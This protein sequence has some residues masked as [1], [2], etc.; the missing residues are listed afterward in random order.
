[1][2]GCKCIICHLTEMIEDEISKEIYD[3]MLEHMEHCENCS[4]LYNTF[5]KT[6]DLFHNIEKIK[7]PSKKKKVFHKWV[8]LEAKKIVIKK[9]RY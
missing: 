9:Y 4:S 5:I 7:L 1:M 8:H 6:I 2:V 3:E